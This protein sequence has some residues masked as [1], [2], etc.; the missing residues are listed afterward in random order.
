MDQHIQHAVALNVKFTHGL[1]TDLSDEQMVAQ[2]R[3][4][5]VFNHPAWVL[6]HLCLY[7]SIA[8]EMLGGDALCPDSWEPLFAIGSKPLPDAAAYP[9]KPVLL[10][11]FTHSSEVAGK[12]LCGAAGDLLQQPA[13]EP[14]RDYF[15]MVG[16][17]ALY[18]LTAHV[19]FH[20]GQLSAWRRAMGLPGLF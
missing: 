17:Y 7:N 10:E 8:A 3:S 11:T 5:V 13:P 18:I 2:P 16:D 19:G 12:A 9:A 6:G 4:E 20:L 15:P 1:V 14:V